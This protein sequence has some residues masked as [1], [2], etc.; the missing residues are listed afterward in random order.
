MKKASKEFIQLETLGAYFLFAVT[1]LAIFLSNSPFADY[2]TKFF[3]SPF[4]IQVGPWQWKN[5]LLFVINEILMSFFFLLVAAEIKYELLQGMLNSLRKALF[6]AIGAIGGMV[7]PAII[8]LGFNYTDPIAIQGWAI[9]TA[10]DIAFALAVLGA[11]GSKIPSSLKIFLAALAIFDDLAAI[12]IIAIFYTENLSLIYLIYSVLCIGLLILF[13]FFHIS[14]LFPYLLLGIILWI[15]LHDSGIHP[16]LAGVVLALTIPLQRKNSPHALL[17]QLKH[18][19]NPWVAL[20][21]LPLFAL[22]NAGIS[23]SSLAGAFDY[24]PIALGIFFGL[25]LGK[26]LGI[27]IICWLAVKFR[28]AQLPDDVTWLEL[29]AAAI[30]CGIGFTISLFIGSLAFYDDGTALVDSV[31][32]GVVAGSL[33]S[34]VLGYLLLHLTHHIKKRHKA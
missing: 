3:Q 11:L 4:T 5:T 16:S 6:P 21:I 29:Y 17:L 22:A 13:N 20:G 8:Y 31:K 25:F 7:V 28:L 12:I 27:I 14:R 33:V 9:P 34:G 32:V 10:T 23:F 19:I 24:L 15:C 2:Y 1:L 18:I 26:Q 30:L